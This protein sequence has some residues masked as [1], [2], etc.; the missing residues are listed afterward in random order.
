MSDKNESLPEDDLLPAP[1]DIRAIANF[2]LKLVGVVV[3]AG[4]VINIASYAAGKAF[5]RR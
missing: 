5:N 1:A 3:A 4:A 2:H